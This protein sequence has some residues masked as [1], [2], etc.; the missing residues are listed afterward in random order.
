MVW[1]K[2]V[3]SSSRYFPVRLMVAEQSDGLA[4]DVYLL[5]PNNSGDKSVELAVTHL[6]PLNAPS[7]IPRHR[8]VLILLHGQYQNRSAFWRGPEQSAGRQLVNAGIDVW[9][10]EMRGHGLS[11]VNADFDS[12]TL[13]DTALYDIPAVTRFVAEMTAER[14]VHWLGAGIGG[15]ALLMS[16]GAGALLGLPVASLIGY[17]DPFGCAG[18]SRLPGLTSLLA[19]RKCRDE[20]AG[21]EMESCAL[22]K[23]LIVESRKLSRRGAA[24]GIDLWYQ[25]RMASVP[26]AWISVD[27]TRDWG[28]RGLR[29][30]LQQGNLTVLELAGESLDT[31][32]SG[33][34]GAGEALHGLPG[35]LT[36]WMNQDYRQEMGDGISAAGEVAPFA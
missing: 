31:V 14:P 36:G 28:E 10:M 9:L 26:L 19:G 24:M 29:N 18:W 33:G 15:G 13:A 7:A 22:I 30:L 4:E 20:L 5:K 32:M 2:A 3:K 25:L 23:N 8:P 35:L 6:S 21:P 16:Q 17:G 12:C 27:K 1:E 11:A 34:C